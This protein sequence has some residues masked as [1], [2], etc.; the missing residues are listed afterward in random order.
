MRVGDWSLDLIICQDDV[1]VSGVSDEIA[2]RAFDIIYILPDSHIAKYLISWLDNF[3]IN[4]ND[5][6]YMKVY[7]I[8]FLIFEIFERHMQ[9]SNIENVFN[10]F[11]QGFQSMLNLRRPI[12]IRDIIDPMELNDIIEGTNWKIFDPSA[13]AR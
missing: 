1:E 5:E 8:I 12:R 2:V 7:F 11:E 6:D 4:R 3:Q 10:R 13:W 9:I